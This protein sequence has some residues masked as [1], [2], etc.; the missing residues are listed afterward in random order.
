MPP[1]F[2]LSW[3]DEVT[4]LLFY[5]LTK[6]DF[7]SWQSIANQYFTKSHTAADYRWSW[8]FQYNC[9]Y[10]GRG[11]GF[12]IHLCYEGGGG[13]IMT[14]SRLKLFDKPFVLGDSLLKLDFP[15]V[16]SPKKIRCSF[17]A[18]ISR[19]CSRRDLTD[20]FFEK[21]QGFFSFSSSFILRLQLLTH[22]PQNAC[23]H[24]LFFLTVKPQT[25]Q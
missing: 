16:S 19:V 1:K 6:Y 10:G 7:H 13:I 9:C 11:G 15:L 12:C 17:G 24:L 22:L 25:A 8:W 18:K 2:N 3:A 4:L 14:Q 5:S 23:H 20:G 21:G